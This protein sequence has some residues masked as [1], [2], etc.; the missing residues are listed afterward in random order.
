M[1]LFDLGNGIILPQ[2]KMQDI[3]DQ[4]IRI[5]KTELPEEAQCPRIMN[6]LLNSVGEVIMCKRLKL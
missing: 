1:T 4:I 6:N 3:V 5:I 2:E